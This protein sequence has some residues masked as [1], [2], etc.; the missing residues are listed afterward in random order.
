MP[1]PAP[2]DATVFRPT[3]VL[4][5]AAGRG[6]RLG[7]G[8]KA[9]LPLGDASVL[10]L[11]LR[12][13]ARLG[14]PL[15]VALPAEAVTETVTGAVAGAWAAALP[16]G[17][18][19]LPGATSRQATVRAL[20]AASREEFVL[21]HDAARPFLPASV[22]R[23]LLAATWATGA[24]SVVRAVAD[25]LLELGSGAALERERLRAVQTPQGFRR[26]WLEEAHAAALRDGVTGTDDAGL[27][28]RRGHA[29]ALVPGSA[30][31]FKITDEADYEIARALAPSWANEEGRDAE[32]AERR[33]AVNDRAEDRRALHPEPERATLQRATR[34]EKSL[35]R[36]STDGGMDHDRERDADA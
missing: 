9:L 20:L 6:E 23:A 24:A 7:R 33:R 1:P 11:A 26:D 29:V 21:V 31:L 36:S 5:P 34:E 14:L 2:P 25:S 12:P 22:L 17:V 18:V 10:A 13:F 4:V 35:E 27:V 28:R 15:Y 32:N 16:P 19:L 30:W 8:P 3:A